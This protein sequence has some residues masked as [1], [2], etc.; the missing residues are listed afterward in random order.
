MLTKRK[1][2]T[3][4]V[5]VTFAMPELDG[6]KQLHLVGDFN[7]W[8]VTETPLK[9]AADG[10]WSVTL[11]L[12]A[13]RKYEFRYYADGQVWHNDWAADAYT[14]NTFGSENSVVDLPAEA[15]K[16]AKPAAPKSPAPKKSA[17]KRKAVK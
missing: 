10:S 15:E 11:T 3:G 2:T 16:P 6:V 14:P 12:E 1:L 7:N 8:S 13:G 5:Q 4:K 9:R 17:P